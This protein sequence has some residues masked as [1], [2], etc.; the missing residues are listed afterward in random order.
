MVALLKLPKLAV[1]SDAQKGRAPQSI[2]RMTQVWMGQACMLQA[3]QRRLTMATAGIS[4]ILE[5]SSTR[6]TSS[7][8]ST[9]RILVPLALKEPHSNG[10]QP[11][12]EQCNK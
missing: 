10:W 4:P 8:S 6:A 11:G 12:T 5:Y 2:P 7:T 9:V 1:G 3:V